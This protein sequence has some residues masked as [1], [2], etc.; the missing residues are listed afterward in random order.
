MNACRRCL[1]TLDF[2]TRT[3]QLIQGDATRIALDSSV[4]IVLTET[5][6]T[7]LGEE[8]QVAITRALMQQHRDAFLIPQSIRVDLALLDLEAEMSSFPVKVC[9]RT[10]LGTVFELNRQ[11]AI[12]LVEENGVLPAATLRLPTRIAPR[13]VPCLTTTIQVF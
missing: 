8:P 6:N 1:T 3:K 12:E 10:I 7:A 9:N 2:L 4:Q 13:L 5:M 11:I